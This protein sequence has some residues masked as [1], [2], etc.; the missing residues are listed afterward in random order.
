MCRG[1]RD[2]VWWSEAFDQLA[3][4]PALPDVIAPMI[5]GDGEQPRERIGGRHLIE[6]TPRDRERLGN[7][8]IGVLA[9]EPSVDDVTPD[10]AVGRFIEGAEAL[11]RVHYKHHVAAVKRYGFLSSLYPSSTPPVSDSGCSGFSLPPSMS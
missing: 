10:G 6:A 8:I 4:A 3:V 9:R 7:Q 2:L 11:L 1:F 5:P